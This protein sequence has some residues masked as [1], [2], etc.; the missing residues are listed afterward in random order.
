MTA[1][2]AAFT[3]KI[4]DKGFLSPILLRE[5]SEVSIGWEV[6]RGSERSKEPSIFVDDGVLTEEWSTEE[7]LSSSNSW[8]VETMN[9]LTIIRNVLLSIAQLKGQVS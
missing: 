9:R 2:N 8:Y 4:F 5:I 3:Y 1:S 6:E 7:D